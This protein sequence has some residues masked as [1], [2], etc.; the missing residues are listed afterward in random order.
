MK[1]FKTVL[2]ALIIAVTNISVTF[3][4][5]SISEL[6]KEKEKIAENSK[7]AKE[8]LK[9]TQEEKSDVLKEVESLDAELTVVEE[10]VER[11]NSLLTETEKKLKQNEAALEKAQEESDRQYKT[12]KKRI[13]TMYENGN[14]GYLQVVLEADN[15]SDMLRRV[16]YV[17]YIMEYD[18]EI[19]ENLEATEAFIQKTVNEIKDEKEILENL[20]KEQET[21]SVELEK[22]RKEKTSL[23]AQ[24]SND[25]ARY[26]QQLNDFEKAD[27]EVTNLIIQAEMA[28]KATESDPSSNKVYPVS[29]G[30]LQYP[31]PAYRGYNYN[32]PYGYRTSPIRGGSEFHTGVDLKATMGCDVV[33]AE[34]GK[35][36]F[37]AINGGYGKCVIID[38]GN[39]MST[40]YA[41]NSKLVVSVGQTVQRGQVI[42]KAGTTG[43]ST[44][45]HVHFEVRLGGKHTNPAP[46][47]GH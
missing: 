18:R 19:F 38:H 30:S 11:I 21:K 10:E 34:S 43:Y 37:S 26:M 24:L 23:V 1:K 41:H 39:G 44:G 5:K 45:V 42:A 7:E 9:K 28:A 29:G 8:E 31:V 27:K 33:A 40:L 17:N 35:V 22:K 4:A 25:E 13:R 14:I 6:N 36:I 46:Y 12:L 20:K 2:I 15:F 3:A 16:D 32:S 47:I